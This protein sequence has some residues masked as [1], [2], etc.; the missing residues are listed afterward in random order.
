MAHMKRHISSTLFVLLL[1]CLLTWPGARFI[2]A[3]HSNLSPLYDVW[4]FLSGRWGSTLCFYVVGLYIA[5]NLRMSPRWQRWCY[6]I[7]L[8][9]CL[10]APF[11][12][13]FLTPETGEAA[14]LT[15]WEKYLSRPSIWLAPAAALS[16]YIFY[17]RSKKRC[18]RRLG[19]ACSS[20][21]QAEG[22]PSNEFG[23]C[24]NGGVMT[25]RLISSLFV[26]CIYSLSTYPFYK[27]LSSMSSEPY[28]SILI[29]GFWIINV[30]VVFMYYVVPLY[31]AEC[32][33]RRLGGKKWVY[34]LPFIV[35]IARHFFQAFIVSMIIPSVA[36]DSGTFLYCVVHWPEGVLVPAVALSLYFFYWKN[37][38]SQNEKNVQE[39]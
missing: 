37:R 22:L 25:R 6:W 35:V 8:L 15:F 4:V 21:K 9:S 12:Y 11:V 27:G 24:R 19:S 3:P 32:W 20:S 16:L 13:V 26:F 14:A 5:T 36:C 17:G 38:A 34:I 2:S 23:I 10:L 30:Q 29:W 31:V 33:S 28:P 7:P 18:E 1:Y 39:L